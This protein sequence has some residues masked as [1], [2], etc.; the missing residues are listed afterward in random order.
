MH[1][2]NI[3]IGTVRNTELQNTPSEHA[4][5]IVYEIAREICLLLCTAHSNA[6]LNTRG[7]LRETE[8]T[9]EECIR[10]YVNEPIFN[11]I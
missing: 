11:F 5:C 9:E 2:V 8:E 6:K 4:G 10:L 1:V 7:V 3:S